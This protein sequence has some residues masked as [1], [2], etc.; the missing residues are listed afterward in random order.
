[1]KLQKC[2]FTDWN[3]ETE[4]KWS[5]G[6]DEHSQCLNRNGRASFGGCHFFFYCIVGPIIQRDSTVVTIA[7]QCYPTTQLP[8]PRL[9]TYRLD[10]QEDT[11]AAVFFGT[12]WLL[13]IFGWKWRESQVIMVWCMWFGSKLVRVW[14]MN[15]TSVSKAFLWSEGLSCGMHNLIAT[16]KFFWTTLGFEF[17]G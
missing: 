5:I 9:K 13:D 8:S 16:W 10:I 17:R 11:K 12:F 15:I 7:I 3:S 1:M 2:G 6:I 14:R 4:T